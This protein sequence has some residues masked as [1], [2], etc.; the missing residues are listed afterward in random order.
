[1]REL[2]LK[3]VRFEEKSQTTK[4]S[5]EAKPRQIGKSL[6]LC[7]MWYNSLNHSQREFE[8][9]TKTLRSN[10]VYFKER[11]IHLRESEIP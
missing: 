9:F 10:R 1:M 2:I 8:E 5:L 7:C 4:D 3:L 11:N 6:S